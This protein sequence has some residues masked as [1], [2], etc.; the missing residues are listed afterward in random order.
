MVLARGLGARDGK[1][2]SLWLRV[3]R[4]WSLVGVVARVGNVRASDV[5]LQLGTMVIL[6]LGQCSFVQCQHGAW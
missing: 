3:P 2:G 5:W 1:Q 6:G 4:I